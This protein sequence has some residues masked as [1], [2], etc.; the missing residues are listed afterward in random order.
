MGL[1]LTTKI[2]LYSPAFSP[3][4]WRRCNRRMTRLLILLIPVAL[5]G[6]IVMV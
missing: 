4:L 3:H 2:P 1:H 5:T 6:K